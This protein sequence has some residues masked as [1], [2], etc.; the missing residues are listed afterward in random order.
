MLKRSQVANFFA[1]CSFFAENIFILMKRSQSTDFLFL[2]NQRF[3]N[4]F[5]KKNKII[6][7]VC[8]IIDLYFEVLSHNFI[9][10]F[11][12]HN[13][14]QKINVLLLSLIFDR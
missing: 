14:T 12:G 7:F 5:A 13:N 2:Q 3:A 11:Q 4:F 6:Q 8:W 10:T 9:F 1:K